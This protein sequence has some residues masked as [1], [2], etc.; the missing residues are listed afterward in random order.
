MG[1]FILLLIGILIISVS[2]F[3]IV[4]QSHTDEDTEV[5]NEFM[6]KDD[7]LVITI[8]SLEN[9]ITDI[10]HTFNKTIRE[11][12]KKYELLETKIQDVDNKVL[13]N[14]LS[15]L[16]SNEELNPSDSHE[17]DIN[18]K[19]DIEENIDKGNSKINHTH[20]KVIELKNKGF[21]IQQIAKELNIGTGEATLILNLK[22]A[23]K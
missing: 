3:F 7:E 10:N 16:Q 14:H 19:I 13:E 9:I 8:E 21:S 6:K 1:S 15:D 22:R 20:L 11:M 17:N 23:R 5:Q 18:N 2:I 4:R 12:E